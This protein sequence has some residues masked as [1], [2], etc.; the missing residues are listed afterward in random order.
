MVKGPLT[1]RLGCAAL[2]NVTASNVPLLLVS[3]AALVTVPFLIVPLSVVAPVSAVV[4]PLLS[5][6][7]AMVLPPVPFKVTFKG[8]ILLAMLAP[9][10]I[11]IVPDASRVSVR[12]PPV[13]L[14]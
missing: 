5:I 2:P 6:V 13:L 7:P 10:W 11:S 9:A 12:V 1:L 4:P 3:V 14:L 8:F